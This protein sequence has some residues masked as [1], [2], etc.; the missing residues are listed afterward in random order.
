MWVSGASKAEEMEKV[1]GGQKLLPSTTQHLK[2]E[3][4]F[5]I[6]LFLLFSP[7]HHIV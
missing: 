7:C 4:M 5:L 2:N 6:F 1:F 3:N